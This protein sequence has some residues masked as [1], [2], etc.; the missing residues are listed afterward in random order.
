MQTCV[1]RRD[2]FSLLR[3]RSCPRRFRSSLATIEK[4]SRYLHGHS[5]AEVRKSSADVCR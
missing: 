2:C 3:D 5:A 4:K 1:D